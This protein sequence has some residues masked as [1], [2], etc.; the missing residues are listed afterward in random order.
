MDRHPEIFDDDNEDLSV[1]DHEDTLDYLA[2]EMEKKLRMTPDQVFEQARLATRFAR[3]LSA[4]VE[5]SP[6]DRK[7]VV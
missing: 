4:D 6:E 7:S 1:L 3:N 5:F 2:S